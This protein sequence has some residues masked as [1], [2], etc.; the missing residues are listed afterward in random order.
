MAVRCLWLL[1]EWYGGSG[2]FF[3]VSECCCNQIFT[4][5]LSMRFILEWSLCFFMWSNIIFFSSV[6]IYSLKFVWWIDLHLSEQVKSFLE[7]YNFF[8]WHYA[9]YFVKQKYCYYYSP[10]FIYFFNFKIFISYMRSQTWTP[11]PPPSP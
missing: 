5:V 4:Q 6:G 10:L 2:K 1:G 8:L 9:G 11:L 7:M 3:N